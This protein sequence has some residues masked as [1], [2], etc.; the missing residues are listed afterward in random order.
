MKAS[1][2]L[3][4]LNK[5][6]FILG[7]SMLD[8]DFFKWLSDPT[9]TFIYDFEQKSR[10]V[11]VFAEQIKDLKWSPII[12]LPKDTDLKAMI[13]YF[14]GRLIDV[15]DSYYSFN[16]WMLRIDLVSIVESYENR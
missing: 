7:L 2:L 1:E 9:S 11:S 12:E 8:D 14:N 13:C 4:S 10:L 6:T 3:K 16:Q 15:F 5:E